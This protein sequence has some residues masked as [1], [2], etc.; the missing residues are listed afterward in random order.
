MQT[1]MLAYVL[2]QNQ[3]LAQAIYNKDSNNLPLT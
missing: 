1:A 2:A 3:Q